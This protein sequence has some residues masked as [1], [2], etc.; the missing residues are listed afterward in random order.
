MLGRFLDGLLYACAVL[1]ALVLLGICLLVTWVVISR[2]WLGAPLGWNVEVTEYA[3]LYLTFLAT[4]WVLRHDGHVRVDV[5][6]NL[7]PVR[8]QRTLRRITDGLALVVCAL[9]FYHS[10]AATA[11]AYRENL[12]LVK[13]LIIPKWPTLAVIPLGFLLLAV[14]LVRGMFRRPAPSGS[15]IEP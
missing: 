7:L 3:L 9:L 10:F 11:E 1:G 14:E 6:V 5:L 2:R 4:A 8:A 12:L 13:M 15:P